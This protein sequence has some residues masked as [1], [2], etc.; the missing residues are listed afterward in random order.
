MPE[1]AELA[2]LSKILPNIKYEETGVGGK[3]TV[4]FSGVNVQ[5]ASGASETE[6]TGVG[7]LI[8][9]TDA[10][11][12][13]QSGSNNLVIGEDQEFTSWGGLVAGQDN[14][15]KGTFSSVTGGRQNE[16]DAE[17]A[18]VSG[19]AANTVSGQEDGSISG[20]ETNSATAV[21]A[22]VCGGQEDVASGAFSV[23]AGGRANKATEL[24]AAVDGG[25]FNLA[26]GQKSS[27]LSGYENTAGFYSSSIF[28]GKK[29]QTKAE[30]G[31]EG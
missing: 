11:P 30:Y 3:P 14:T 22:S 29:L 13:T 26:S 20:G 15:V 4:E 16:A 27:V 6:A 1:P 5:V 21:G 7:N 23:A 25:Q 2:T 12:R 18:V 10:S 8:V 31:V 28:G 24:D 19:G 9:G 17:G